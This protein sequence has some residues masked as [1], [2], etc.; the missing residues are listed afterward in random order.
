MPTVPVSLV[1]VPSGKAEALAN[2]FN[3]KVEELTTDHR[4]LTTGPD[5]IVDATPLGMKGPLESETL[6]TADELAGVRF[7]YDLVTKSADTPLIREAKLAGIPAI[8]GLEMLI[9]Q[10]AKQ[11]EIWTGREAP[12]EMMKA[13][14]T[15]KLK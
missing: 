6:F 11:F 2:E 3:V 7:V 10:G 1:M 5:I 12:V 13:G 9:A 15:E 8:G 4:P 14:V